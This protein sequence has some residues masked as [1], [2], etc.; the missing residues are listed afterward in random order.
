MPTI[1]K[2]YNICDEYT[3]LIT[4]KPLSPAAHRRHVREAR[5][6]KPVTAREMIASEAEDWRE[7]FC[8]Q[9]EEVQ[10]VLT[11]FK[12][13]PALRQGDTFRSA[14]PYAIFTTLIVLASIALKPDSLA[15]RIMESPMDHGEDILKF[16][17]YL[18]GSLALC[19]VVLRCFIWGSAE[20][21]SLITKMETREEKQKKERKGIP[22]SD[23]LL[24]GFCM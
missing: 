9:L 4:T 20:F 17:G 3:M 23:L 15:H 21:A 18:F 7:A 8:P 12:C 5:L 1:I 13:D 19:L 24:G 10:E 14:A 16:F 22:T 6:Q 11:R 2:R